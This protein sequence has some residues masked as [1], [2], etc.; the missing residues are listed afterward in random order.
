MSKEMKDDFSLDV[1]IEYNLSA[2]L[3]VFNLWF[4]TENRP[5]MED[6]VECVIGLGI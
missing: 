3:G 6:F 4:T 5:S 2:M 1:L